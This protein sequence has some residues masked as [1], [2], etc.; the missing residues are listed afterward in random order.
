MFFIVQ[1]PFAK[2]VMELC[3]H[4]GTFFS[5]PAHLQSNSTV[6]HECAVRDL[7]FWGREIHPK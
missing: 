2:D 6:G 1:A 4:V 3:G 5:Q 7:Q